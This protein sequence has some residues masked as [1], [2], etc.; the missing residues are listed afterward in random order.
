M[1][2]LTMTGLIA[3]ALVTERRRAEFSVATSSEALARL[4]RLGSIGE[5]AAAVAHEVNQPLIAAGVY[6]R[7][8]ADTISLGNANSSEVAETV[9]KAVAQ[10]D[11]AGE[12]IRRLRALVRLDRSNRTSL[13]FERIVNQTIELCRPDLDRASVTARYCPLTALPHVMVDVLQIE[14]V[15]LNLVRN[16]VEAISNSGNRHGSILIEA[17]LANNDFVEVRLL[18]RVQAFRASRSKTASFLYLPPSLRVWASV[19]RYASQLLRRMAADGGSITTRLVHQSTLRY[20]SPYSPIMA[21]LVNLALI[22]DDEAV[23][24]ALLHYLT[25][26]SVKTSCFNAAKSFLTT[27]NHGA[28]F[29]CIV[30]DVRMPGMT[31]LDLMR[32]L[33]ERAY[34]PPV[35][36]ITGHGDVDMAVA[37]IKDGAFDFIEKPFDEA[38]LLASIRRAVKQGRQRESHRR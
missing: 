33:N 22:D 14:Q 20:P 3:G 28:R 21:D 16:S 4:T 2:I 8:V 34:A 36:L 5:L 17:K 24:D 29:D 27:L 32:R 23:L 1:L 18:T 9:K 10:V 19:C 30:S 31:G 11:R 15:M 26:Q 35:I 38:R 13:S 25:C 12:V 37:A 6:M 7:L